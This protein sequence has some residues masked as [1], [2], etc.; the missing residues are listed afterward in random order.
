MSLRTFEIQGFQS[1]INPQKIE[2]ET[3][4]TVLAGRN[5]VGKSALLRALY[6]P[7]RGSPGETSQ[8]QMKYEWLIGRDYLDRK[9]KQLLTLFDAWSSS[10]KTEY[11]VT[12]TIADVSTLD[13]NSLLS[14]AIVPP[15]HNSIGGAIPPNRWVSGLINRQQV[16]EIALMDSNLKFSIH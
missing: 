6:L 13:S 1:Y 5:N 16:V 11:L 3:H 15:I 8:K 14:H 4:L 7:V 2:L 9:N 12:A 10:R